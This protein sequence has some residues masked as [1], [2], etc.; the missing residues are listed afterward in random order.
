MLAR[1]FGNGVLGCLQVDFMCGVALDREGAAAIDVLLQAT[2]T[3]LVTNKSNP[4]CLQLACVNFM[5]RIKSP[6]IVWTHGSHENDHV[7]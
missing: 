7:A 3:L 6:N 2:T 1:G 4:I 5:H